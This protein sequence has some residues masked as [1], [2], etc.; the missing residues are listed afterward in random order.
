MIL[1]AL[2]GTVHVARLSTDEAA[3]RLKIKS[4]TLRAAFCRAGHYFGARPTKTASRFLLW[5]AADI[6]RL[7]NGE[8]LQ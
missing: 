7:A 1:T 8:V 6:E 4:Q 3:S 2:S 5:N